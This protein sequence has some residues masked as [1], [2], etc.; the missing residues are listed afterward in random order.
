MISL[1]YMRDMLQ[2]WTERM[3]EREWDVSTT[4]DRAVFC[5]R[6]LAAQS[7]L[8]AALSVSWLAWVLCPSDVCLYCAQ[9]FKDWSA[10]WSLHLWPQT[11]PVD[12]IP[13][14]KENEGHY[15]V[16]IFTRRADNDEQIVVIH[17]VKALDVVQE[18]SEHINTLVCNANIYYTNVY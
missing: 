9:T 17:S 13:S 18:G 2:W 3:K 11:L 4:V 10:I 6:F 14:I 8:I 5:S 7:Q 16:Y 1:Q 15:S 12:T